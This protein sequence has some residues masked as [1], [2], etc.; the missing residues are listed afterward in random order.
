MMLCIF[1]W[2]FHFL[3]QNLN[4][5]IFSSTLHII[6]ENVPPLEAV[7][8]F[9]LFGNASKQILLRFTW[10]SKLLG[11]SLLWGI[12]NVQRRH[13]PMLPC[14]MQPRFMLYMNLY[15][16]LNVG[17]LLS[18]VSTTPDGYVMQCEHYSLA[19]KP[20]RKYT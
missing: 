12:S 5:K 11:I 20:Q 3:F 7:V 10:Y 6:W 17:N 1:W 9:Y 14:T 16:H 8:C 2:V 18:F 19:Q 4:T 15:M 13:F